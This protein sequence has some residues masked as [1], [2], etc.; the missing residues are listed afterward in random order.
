MAS[1]RSFLKRNEE[2]AYFMG[3]QSFLFDWEKGRRIPIRRDDFLAVGREL[4]DLEEKVAKRLIVGGLREGAKVFRLA[5]QEGVPIRR[6]TGLS[7]TVGRTGIRY[8]G[9]LRRGIIYRTDPARVAMRPVVRVGPRTSAFY[10]YFFE[11]GRLARRFPI[12]RYMSAA[13]TRA[14]YAAV[15]AVGDKMA[16][17]LFRAKG[18]YT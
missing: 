11:T 16:A 5:A 7:K 13:F 4:N 2:I 1:A 12:R 15:A 17:G 18:K 9:F 14:H 10:G 6:S 8:P 3:P